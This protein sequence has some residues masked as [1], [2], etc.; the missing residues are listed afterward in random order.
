VTVKVAL[1]VAVP[2]GVVT[3]I[4]PVFA[5]LGTV[6]VIFVYE[7]TA[8][9]VALTPPKVALVAPVK[10]S[11]LIVTLVPGGPLVGETLE[12]VGVTRKFTLLV[13][14]RLGVVTLIFPV[15][16]PLGTVV[17]I[18]VPA[19]LTVNVA[20]VPLKVTLV[21]PC[22]IVSQDDDFCPHF[23]GGGYRFHERCKTHGKGK[24]RTRTEGPATEG[25]PVESPIGG[26]N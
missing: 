16:A 4:F 12:I 7:F 19:E 9:L 8:K 17:V 1:L 24:D 5:P 15:V 21:A 23:A 20:A 3:L 10:L 11:P 14:V 25:C 22:Q 26:F 18:A 2:T 6:A 13:N